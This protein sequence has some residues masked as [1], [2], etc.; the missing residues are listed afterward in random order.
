MLALPSICLQKFM[1]QYII[2]HPNKKGEN[3]NKIPSSSLGACF[4]S[5]GRRM[6][7]ENR[8]CVRR[9]AVLQFFCKNLYS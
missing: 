7:R 6:G 9:Q 8:P 3:V 5:P 1:V 4:L 2:S